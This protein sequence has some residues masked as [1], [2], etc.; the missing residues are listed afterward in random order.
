MN[1]ILFVWLQK[2]KEGGGR[3]LGEGVYESWK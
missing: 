1:M 2:L 3:G